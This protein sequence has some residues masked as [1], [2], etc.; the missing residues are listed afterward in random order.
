MELAK[1]ESKLQK[2]GDIF[3]LQ[4]AIQSTLICSTNLT[5]LKQVLKLVMVK[6]GLRANNWPAGEEKDILY[7]HIYSNYGGNRIEEIG[8]AFEMANAGKLD[9]RP[10]DVKCYENFSC[11]YFSLIMNAY[12]TWA[13]REVR[14]L[15]TAEI[16]PQRIFTDV[17]LEN[18]ARE[19][20]EL[21]YQRFLRGNKLFGLMYNREILIKDNLLKSGGCNCEHS[22]LEFFRKQMLAGKLNIYIN[23]LE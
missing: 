16:P 11:A 10:E 7:H 3:C 20:A 19:N 15:E 23:E 18:M 9:L 5:E 8:L 14:A 17:E 22:V 21:Q 2:S 13:A 4:R 6:V 12:R 1:Q